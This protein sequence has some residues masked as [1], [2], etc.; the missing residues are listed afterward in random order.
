MNLTFNETKEKKETEKTKIKYPN[1]VT[2]ALLFCPV[3]CENDTNMAI[4][5]T[6]YKNPTKKKIMNKILKSFS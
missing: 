5:L 2:R 6:P 4:I 1:S 3:L